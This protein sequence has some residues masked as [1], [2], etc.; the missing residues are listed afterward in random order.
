M[1]VPFSSLFLT[2]LSGAGTQEALSP[3]QGE[4]AK[5]RDFAAKRRQLR[6]DF[7]ANLWT[8]RAAARPAP[9]R[10]VR[11]KRFTSCRVRARMPY[12]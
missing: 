8:T 2:Y 11:A 3:R 9:A 5:S 4:T 10:R 7:P 6:L 12:R 1:N